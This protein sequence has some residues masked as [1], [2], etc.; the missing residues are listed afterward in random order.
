MKRNEEREGE[1]RFKQEQKLKIPINN[2]KK[3]KWFVKLTQ[4]AFTN[5]HRIFFR[6]KKSVSEWDRNK[7]VLRVSHVCWSLFAIV[8]FDCRFIVYSH[9]PDIF[10]FLYTS[11]TLFVCFFFLLF[12]VFVDFVSFHAD[13]AAFVFRLIS[14]GF[15][16]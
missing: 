14:S 3:L 15:A 8:N 11:F 9:S 1:K 6:S 4:L 12:V 13:Y 5:P 7:C 16:F 2:N 10:T